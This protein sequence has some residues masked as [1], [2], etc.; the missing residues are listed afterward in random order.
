MV[1][2]AALPELPSMLFLDFTQVPLVEDYVLRA[3]AKRQPG[4][5]VLNYYGTRQ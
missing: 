5:V 4:A 1:D 2:A 3:L